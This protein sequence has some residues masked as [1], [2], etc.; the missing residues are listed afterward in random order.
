MTDGEGAKATS[1]CRPR[2]GSGAKTGPSCRNDAFG[3]N[4]RKFKTRM[5]HKI[6]NCAC[7]GD[8]VMNGHEG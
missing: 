4:L 3:E 8:G 6:G 5:G 1:F 7:H 2:G